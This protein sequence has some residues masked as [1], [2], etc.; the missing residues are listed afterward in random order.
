L[1]LGHSTTNPAPKQA[2][3]DSNTTSPDSGA[4][5]SPGIDHIDWQGYRNGQRLMSTNQGPFPR[6]WRYGREPTREMWS[7]REAWRDHREVRTR[8]VPPQFVGPRFATELPLHPPPSSRTHPKRSTHSDYVSHTPNQAPVG[9]HHQPAFSP[10]HR[11]FVRSWSLS[12][13][14]LPQQQQQQLLQWPPSPG[15]VMSPNILPASTTPSYAS[16]HTHPFKYPRSMTLPHGNTSQRSLEGGRPSSLSQDNLLADDDRQTQSRK[17]AFKHPGVQSSP[18]RRAQSLG[19][20]TWPLGHETPPIECEAPPLGHDTPPIGH[21]SHMAPPTEH[22]HHQRNSDN[23]EGSRLVKSHTHID[24]NHQ[25]SQRLVK[26]QDE[27]GMRRVK[28][29]GSSHQEKHSHG[30]N[31][32]HQHRDHFQ[33]EQPG[34]QKEQQSF[35]LGPA[36]APEGTCCYYDNLSSVDML[37]LLLDISS[38]HCKI[39]TL[40][41]VVAPI[42]LPAPPF[43]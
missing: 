33:Q 12:V 31:H 11:N 15:M 14:N 1:I 20:G 13:S 30:H 32:H 29:Q 43:P 6:A 38:P 16:E 25:G 42:P 21:S 26:S 18:I 36:P 24:F 22:T 5:V 27:G 37:D 2:M 35:P 17:S 8:P 23:R 40:E 19:H 9:S 3:F 7:R 41:Y 39:Q 28:T 4:S 34:Q 10:T